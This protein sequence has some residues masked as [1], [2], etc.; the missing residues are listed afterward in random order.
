MASLLANDTWEIVD[1]PPGVKPIPCK[2]VFKLKM[3]AQGSVARYKARLVVQGFR[4]QEGV[5]YNEV[6]APVAKFVTGQ[7]PHVS[8]S[9]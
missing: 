5:D 7:N 3:D 1:A 9:K 4:R 8:G 6:F 2:W